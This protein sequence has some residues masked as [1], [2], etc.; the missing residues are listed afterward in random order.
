MKLHQLIVELRPGEPLKLFLPYEELYRSLTGKELPQKNIALPG[1]Q[2]NI[3]DRQMQIVVE[4]RRIATVLG[5]VPN[6]GY[7]L[8]NVGG[9]YR[10]IEDIIKIPPVKRVGARSY[11]IQEAHVQFDELVGTF[12]RKIYQPT[13]IVTS[14]R[15]VG[16]SFV[17]TDNQ[18][19]A[20]ITFGPMESSQ[21][22]GLFHFKPKKLPEVVVF[23]DVDYYYLPSKPIEMTERMLREFV[24]CGV[25]FAEKQSEVVKNILTL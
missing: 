2:L 10:K 5:D 24:S 25:E 8:D 19:N 13:A 3:E 4:P 14:S 21:L 15:D 9:A 18:Y 6:I 17:L 16:A 23:V 20:N 12:K 7:C 22:E 11:W 1:F